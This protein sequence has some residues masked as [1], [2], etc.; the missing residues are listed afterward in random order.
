MAELKAA[1]EIMASKGSGSKVLAVSAILLVDIFAELLLF[2]DGELLCS[3]V[4]SLGEL[5]ESCVLLTRSTACCFCAIPVICQ[6]F[7]PQY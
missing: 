3:C 7:P 1:Q 2:P 5:G 4:Q 6:F